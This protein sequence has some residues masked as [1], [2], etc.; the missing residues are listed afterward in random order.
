MSIVAAAAP[1]LIG[2]YMQS[3]ICLETHHMMLG[4]YQ[5]TKNLL[6]SYGRSTGPIP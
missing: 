5:Q 6:V 3:G 1:T 4:H 2:G